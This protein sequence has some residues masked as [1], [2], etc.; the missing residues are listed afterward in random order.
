MDKKHK[1]I[2]YFLI[3]FAIA[4]LLRT[5]LA[6]IQVYY[7]WF[8]LIIVVLLIIIISYFISKKVFQERKIKEGEKMDKLYSK[9]NITNRN[10]PKR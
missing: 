8:Y 10:A 9:I 1:K 6:Y 3:I 5:Y 4:I 7:G 2:I